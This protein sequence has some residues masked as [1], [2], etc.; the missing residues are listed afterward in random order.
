MNELAEVASAYFEE[1]ARSV[2]GQ[3][4]AMANDLNREAPRLVR[5]PNQLNEYI[6]NQTA[7]R[8]V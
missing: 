5:N 8:V 4:L 6:S 1:H 2:R 3:I 7:L